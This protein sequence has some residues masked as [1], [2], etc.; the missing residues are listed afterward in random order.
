MIQLS[1]YLGFFPQGNYTASIS[2]FDLQEGSFVN[3][4]P[5]HSY[6]LN[7]SQS[8]LLGDLINAQYDTIH[9][10][11]IDKNQRKQLLQGLIKFY[12]LH[13]ASFGEIKSLEILEEVIG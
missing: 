1:R 4:T 9:Q 12:Q 11:K 13:I 6:Y 3:H 7:A 2:V 10:L 8:M 5:H